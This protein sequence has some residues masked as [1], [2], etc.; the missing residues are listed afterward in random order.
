[1]KLAQRV[2]SPPNRNYHHEVFVESRNTLYISSSDGS[3]QAYRLAVSSYMIG[4]GLSGQI[5]IKHF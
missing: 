4:C 1:M 5:L 3:T 2:A